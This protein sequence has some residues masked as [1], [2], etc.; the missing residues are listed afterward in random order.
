V[1]RSASRNFWQSHP[2]QIDIRARRAM[3][4]PPVTLVGLG[5]GCQGHGPALL[6]RRSRPGHVREAIPRAASRSPT[7]ITSPA[8]VRPWAWRAPAS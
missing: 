5:A 6:S 2:A 1:S 4:A 3:P 8:S 7:R